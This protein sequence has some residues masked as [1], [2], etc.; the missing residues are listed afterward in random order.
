[1]MKK[2]FFWFITL[3]LAVVIGVLLNHH[4][5]FVFISVG[6]WSLETSLF[7]A[8][9]TLLSI[10]ILIH[11]TLDF[12]HWLRF[13]PL[14]LK[15]KLARHRLKRAH[16]KTRQGLIEFSEGHWRQA[17]DH[18]IKGL[19]DTDTPLLNYLTAARAAQEMGDF[20][21]RD[22]YLR[23]AQ[24]IMPEAR[25][26]IELTQAQLQLA[27]QQW[28]QALATL[29]HLQSLSPHHAYVLKLLV[30]LYEQ[31]KDWRDLIDLLPEIK[32]K[33]IFNE[34][35]FKQLQHR[36][37]KEYLL[38]LIKQDDATLIKQLMTS[39]PSSLID[40]NDLTLQYA[41]YLIYK[42]QQIE[43]ELILRKA[44]K[45][46]YDE[47]LMQC[48]G[49][50]NLGTKPLVFAETFLK[51]HPKA[52]VLL[53]ALGRLSKTN[54]LWGKAKDYLE[55]SIENGPTMAAYFTLGD[56]LEELHDEKG[57]LLA[58]REGLKLNMLNL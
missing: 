7:V 22:Q 38:I 40:N 23:E 47:A 1:M 30:Q 16:L 17:K 45:R 31:I 4:R 54:L 52:S 27:H 58:Y 32:K 39:L 18:L 5:G 25:I 8:G 6:H 15:N 43:A 44:L 21:Q 24:Q 41:Q 28:E 35:D 42:N 34:L 2:A 57:A 36:A 46:Q 56:L 11:Y 53:L 48:Y 19:K 9:L 26:A 12:L 55:Q 29:R 49:L 37:Y 20:S 51:T 3:L 50:L 14:M 33:N 13:F 10:F